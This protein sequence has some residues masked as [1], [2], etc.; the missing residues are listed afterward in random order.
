MKLETFEDIKF[1]VRDRVTDA[2]K[3]EK[4]ERLSNKLGID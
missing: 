4:A 1:Y 3:D 2:I